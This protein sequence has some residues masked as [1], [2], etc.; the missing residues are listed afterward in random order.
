MS[1]H[2]SFDRDQRGRHAPFVTPKPKR[3]VNDELQFHL[4]QRIQSYIA[5]GMAPDAARRKALE[6]FGD[7][8]GV[9]EE[10][11][12]LLTEDRKAEARRDWF[13][14]LR[15]DLRFAVRSAVKAPVFSLLAIVT[16]A[17]GIGANAAVFGVVK[18]VLLDALPYADASRLVRI[19]APMRTGGIK[20][21]SLSAGTISDIR[22]R[23]HAFTSF[24]A[25][26][27][28]RDV[29]YTNGTA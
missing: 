9:R 15:Q 13:D 27:G 22:E 26:Q 10:C 25:F 14:D 5:S 18:S 7:V 11:A 12:Q 1:N 20:R 2:D 19:F 28:P 23:Q 4:E 16:L 24:G 8:D 21:V 3:E 17:L 6:R 29:V